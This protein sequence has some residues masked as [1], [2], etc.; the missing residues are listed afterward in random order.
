[1]NC[2]ITC[3]KTMIL[4]EQGAYKAKSGKNNIPN[5]R[6]I[7]GGSEL[8][9]YRLLG[10]KNGAKRRNGGGCYLIRQIKPLKARCFCID[11][12]KIKM[13]ETNH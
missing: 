11:D 2:M 9:L 3:I 12:Q 7:K 5:R 13:Q 8:V 10:G 1:M 4:Q 6:K